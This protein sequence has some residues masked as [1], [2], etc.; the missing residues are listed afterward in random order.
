MQGK[1]LRF[2]IAAVILAGAVG[3]ALALYKTRPTTT[4]TQPLEKLWTVEVVHVQPQRLAPE[5]RLYGEVQSP[6][7]ARLTAAINAEVVEVSAREGEVVSNNQ[8]LLRLDDR[9]ARIALNSREA[10]V[11]DAQAQIDAEHQRHAADEQA[12]LHDQTLLELT[13][14][15]VERAET[16]AARKLIPDSSVDQSHEAQERQALM[17]NNRRLALNEHPA[18]LR[19]L[20]ARLQRAQAAREQ[21]RL[22]VARTRI[23]APFGGR[24]ARVH[25]TAGSRVRAGDVLLEMYS[26]ERL[27]IRSQIP[28][29]HIAALRH[30]LARKEPLVVRGRLDGQ[31]I[32][33]QLE[34]LAGAAAERRVGMDAFFRIT[35]G[36]AV[37][38]LGRFV[39]LTL[40]LSPQDGLYALPPQAVYSND[41]VYQV[42]NGRMVGVAV[43]RVGEYPSGGAAARVLVRAPLLPAHAQVIVTP[44][45]NAV[46]GLPVKVV[47]HSSPP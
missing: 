37:A 7:V 19:Q 25:S 15:A 23:H 22:E 1:P 43:E 17:V 20:Q 32:E 42:V 9:D 5:I 10:D 3:G 40:S 46:E 4:V 29:P 28:A 39:D 8:M 16:L 41:K 14:R 34:R 35:H 45:P 47:A 27:E 44:L 13:R 18:R 30:A 24:I 26:N 36:A 2:L 33:A 38:T 6:A 31:V 11:Q 21:A 12:L